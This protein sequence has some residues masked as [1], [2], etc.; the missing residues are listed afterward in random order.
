[1]GAIRSSLDHEG[2]VTQEDGGFEPVLEHFLLHPY[3]FSL[4]SQVVQNFTPLPYLSYSL[5]DFALPR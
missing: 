3:D 4:P 5:L 1:M 2:M